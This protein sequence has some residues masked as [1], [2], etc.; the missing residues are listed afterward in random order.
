M[1]LCTFFRGMRVD[2]RHMSTKNFS[3]GLNNNKCHIIIIIQETHWVCESDYTSG[4]WLCVHTRGTTAPLLRG[5]VA[6]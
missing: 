3:L 5:P 6:C 4:Q 1:F 2:S